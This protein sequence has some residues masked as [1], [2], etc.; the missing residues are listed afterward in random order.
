MEGL[1]SV[2]RPFVRFEVMKHLSAYLG[3]I[4]LLFSCQGTKID[5]LLRPTSPYEKYL[6]DLN[7]STLKNSG[8]VKEWIRVGE[9][10]L[11]D[12]N[13][14]ELP[15]QELTQFD[16]A[17][18]QAASFQFSVKEGQQ[19]NISLLPYS[20]STATYF[21]DLFEVRTG[22]ELKPIKPDLSDNGLTY[23]AGSDASYLL[24]VQP[25]LLKGGLVEI[26][27]GFEG[28][29]GFP[30]LDKTHL[31]IASFFGAARDGGR[32]TH[33]GVDV[34]AARGTPVVA[35]ADGR[36]TR[37]GTNRLGGNTVSVS[38]GKYSFYY[39]H[40]DSQ[41]VS[42]GKSVRR[43]DTLGTVGNTGNAITTAPHLHFGIYAPGR[44]SIDP[45]HFFIN[46]PVLP[47]LSPSDTSSLSTWVRVKGEVVNLRQSPSTTSPILDK[48]AKHD[49]LRVEGKMKG[50]L[51]IRLP[52]DRQ[53][54]IAENLVE[55]AHPNLTQKEISD[56]DMV[57]THWQYPEFQHSYFAGSVDLLGKYGD[58]D[59]VKTDSGTNLWL[60]R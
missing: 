40:L 32:R 56:D 55:L 19:V 34:F 60:R 49:V 24:R 18:P 42:M 3:L 43:G 7:S 41:L 11:Q 45:L 12:S 30:V 13:R 5:Q 47:P 14:I 37:V 28:T 4:L 44:R 16:P 2:G 23:P 27:I 35:A 17:V 31:N 1:S 25:E 10:V 54:F 26:S 6:Q 29:L 22:Q 39:A 51:R 38:S 52:D 21:L 9:S 15:Y 46:A 48:L 50:W 36:V 8:M 57:K 20:D 58:F 53:G 59:Y 33:E